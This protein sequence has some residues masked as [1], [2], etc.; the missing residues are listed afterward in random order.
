MTNFPKDNSFYVA[1]SDYE[2]LENKLNSNDLNN[3]ELVE[4]FKDQLYTF[5]GNDDKAKNHKADDDNELID[6]N[7]DQSREVSKQ[8]KEEQFQCTIGQNSF[9]GQTI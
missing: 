6:L 3:I 9:R 5:I 2:F 1:E 4:E 7:E 8:A